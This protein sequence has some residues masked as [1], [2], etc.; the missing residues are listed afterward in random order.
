MTETAA[1]SS[2]ASALHQK[3][4]I[5]NMLG[6]VN[7]FPTVA[8]PSFVLPEV[9]AKGGTTAVSWTLAGTTEYVPETATRCAV[10]LAA[11]HH[12]DPPARLVRTADDIREAKTNGEAAIIVNF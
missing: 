6:G 4:L 10:A 1:A 5:V 2:Q 3:A 7:R 11:I 9:M 8:N 12:A